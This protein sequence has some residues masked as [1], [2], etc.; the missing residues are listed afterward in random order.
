M[1]KSH[2][3][4]ESSQTDWYQ[5]CLLEAT[6]AKMSWLIRSPEEIPG[7]AV[8]STRAL[9]VWKVKEVFLNENDYL[10]IVSQTCDIYRS[11][12]KEP[13]IEAIRAFK[14]SDKGIMKEAMTSGRQF[15]L[16][17][18]SVD[19]FEEALIADATVRLHIAKDDLL[20]LKP[21]VCFE[22]GDKIT[23]RMFSQWLAKR[24]DRQA[25]PD[26]IVDAVQK[27]IVNSIKKLSK[28]N[29]LHRIFHGIWQIRFLL[30]TTSKGTAPLTGEKGG[31]S[32]KMT[33]VLGMLRV[34]KTTQQ[35]RCNRQSNFA[36]I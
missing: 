23:P 10:I 31:E 7:E 17:R 32:L 30:R 15:L 8:G 24:Y 9:G 18:I 5:G 11:S 21:L 35:S 4:V 34:C 6:S 1:A 36:P 29:D 27:P 25:I 2:I 22:D 33:A 14:T 3:V 16:R 19:G 12:L 26:D 13:Y 28:M 20:K